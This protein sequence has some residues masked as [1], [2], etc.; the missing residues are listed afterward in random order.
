LERTPHGHWSH[1]PRIYILLRLVNQLEAI[2]GFLGQNVTDI[3][4]PFTQKSLPDV[5]RNHYA[6]LKFIELQDLVYSTKA[7]RLEQ[8]DA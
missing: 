3:S 4:L 5:L 2:D 7:L 8:D 1:I 6:R